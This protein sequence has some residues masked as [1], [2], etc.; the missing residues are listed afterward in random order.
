MVVS[1]FSF[2]RL[3]WEAR[4]AE[5]TSRAAEQ[6]R[7]ARERVMIA[8]ESATIATQQALR[9]QQLLAKQS[10]AKTKRIYMQYVGDGQRGL[11]KDKQNYLR[12]Q[13]YLMPGSG[14]QVPASQSPHQNQVRYFN[15]GDDSDAATIAKLLAPLVTGKV[16]IQ[17]TN[18]PNGVVP[19]GQ[20]EIWLAEGTTETKP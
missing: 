9:D 10:I 15:K 17:S 20:F 8:Q 2:Q 14:E 4:V 13:S 3:R 5:E 1:F 6:A 16:A 12:K 7:L 18:N 11:V 19:V